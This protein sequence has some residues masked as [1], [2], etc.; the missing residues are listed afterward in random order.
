M[1]DDIQARKLPKRRYRSC[2]RV[3]RRITI[4]NTNVKHAHHKIVTY[5]AAAEI[6]VFNRPAA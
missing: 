1:L 2:P 4:R 6:F 5:D 3:V